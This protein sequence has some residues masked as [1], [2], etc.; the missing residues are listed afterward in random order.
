MSRPTTVTAAFI[1]WIVALAV[2]LAVTVPAL[3]ALAE[4]GPR[5]PGY[6]DNLEVTGVDPSAVDSVAGFGGLAVVLFLSAFELVLIFVMRSGRNWARVLLTVFGG[7][8]ILGDLSWVINAGRGVNVASMVVTALA[9][10]LMYV[11]GA[12]AFFR[13][14]R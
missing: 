2:H 10:V 3:V 5:I 14:Q 8:G 12:N 9:I 7:L 6:L 11:G 4:G 1:A 13:R